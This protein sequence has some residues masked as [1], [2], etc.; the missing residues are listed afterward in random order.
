[1]RPN[2][3]KMKAFDAIRTENKLK[4]GEWKNLLGNIKWIFLVKW[5]IYLHLQE[6]EMLHQE[7]HNR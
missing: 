4:Q 1:M 7:V 6:E 5:A 2:L 3:F